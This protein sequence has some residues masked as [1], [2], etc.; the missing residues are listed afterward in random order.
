MKKWSIILK[1][2]IKNIY[3]LYFI[4]LQILKFKSQMTSTVTILVAL[5]PTHNA[6]LLFRFKLKCQHIHKNYKHVI[7]LV[8]Y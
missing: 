6:L 3:I 7:K 5:Y 2:V 4:A 1:Y 8:L